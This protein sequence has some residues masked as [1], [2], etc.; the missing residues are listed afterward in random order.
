MRVRLL[1]S[2]PWKPLNK[3][4]QLRSSVY[5]SLRFTA[6]AWRL[7]QQQCIT[8]LGQ[9]SWFASA[10]AETFKTTLKAR[11]SRLFNSSRESCTAQS[12]TSTSVTLESALVGLALI[13]EP[14]EPCVRTK[15]CSGRSWTA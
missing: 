3:P 8:K 7:G 9:E 4:S 1:L 10:V 5:H 14:E 11:T 15:S 2:V 12:R 6:V 13:C